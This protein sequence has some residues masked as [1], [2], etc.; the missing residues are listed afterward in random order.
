MTEYVTARNLAQLIGVTKRA[1]IHH[2]ESGKLPA[3]MIGC[4]YLIVAQDALEFAE[5]R[6]ERKRK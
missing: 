6:V 2:I 1:I 4:Q 5:K 3:R